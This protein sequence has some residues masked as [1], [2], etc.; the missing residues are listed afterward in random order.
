[1]MKPLCSPFA[2]VWIEIPDEPLS[3]RQP[4]ARLPT[5][6]VARRLRAL[7]TRLGAALRGRFIVG[8]M[9]G[10]AAVPIKG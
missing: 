6:G 9:Q 5:L 2:I 3:P 7:K 4:G 8:G 10:E 1:M